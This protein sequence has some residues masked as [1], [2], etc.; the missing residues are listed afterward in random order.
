M[1]FSSI[2][3]IFRNFINEVNFFVWEKT[4]WIGG[5]VE[6]TRVEEI[7]ADEVKETNCEKK[8]G[9]IYFIN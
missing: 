9:E 4:K 2:V 5:H 7:T 6:H 8:T 1:G 3:F